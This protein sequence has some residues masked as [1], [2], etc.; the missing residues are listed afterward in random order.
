MDLAA[1]DDEQG[2]EGGQSDVEQGGLVQ[3][4]EADHPYGEQGGEGQEHDPGQEPPGSGDPRGF[5]APSD[6]RGGGAAA[7]GVELGR[8]PLGGAGLLVVGVLGRFG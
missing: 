7:R 1:Q 8:L 6:E 3:A 5:G 2:Q 4:A